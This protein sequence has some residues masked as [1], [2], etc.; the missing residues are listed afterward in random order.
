MKGQKMRVNNINNNVNFKAQLKINPDISKLIPRLQVYEHPERIANYTQSFIDSIKLLKETA[1]I[2]GEKSDVIALKNGRD[3]L[4]PMIELT[5]N[6]GSHRY[7]D[8]TDDPLLE[9]TNAIQ[10]MTRYVLSAK[11]LAPAKIWGPYNLEEGKLVRKLW[12]TIARRPVNTDTEITTL[13]ELT[14]KLEKLISID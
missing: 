10:K 7:I 2:I 12:E 4:S 14:A 3:I 5:Y 11:D 1:P 13:E 8:I 9:T 6:G